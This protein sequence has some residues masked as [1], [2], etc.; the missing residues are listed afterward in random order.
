M[1]VAE[2]SL[3]SFRPRVLAWPD[4]RDASG[5]EAASVAPMIGSIW[6]RAFEATAAV[7][8]AACCWAWLLIGNCAGLSAEPPVPSS[9][10]GSRTS[11][12]LVHA[13][14]SAAAHITIE[15]G[16]I[17]ATCFLQRLSPRCEASALREP[18]IMKLLNDQVE[19]MPR[20]CPW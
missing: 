1:C 9:A 18:S 11:F 19:A 10:E 2:E 3:T 8:G 14:S 5:L 20:E 12:E 6:I 4:R 17:L 16:G 7:C 15:R 13:E